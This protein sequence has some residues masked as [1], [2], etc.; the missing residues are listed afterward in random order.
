[1]YLTKGST[2]NVSYWRYKYCIL[3]REVLYWT[4]D[5]LMYVLTSKYFWKTIGFFMNFM[6]VNTEHKTFPEKI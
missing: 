3:L 4:Q 2:A 5:F 6:R 1:M